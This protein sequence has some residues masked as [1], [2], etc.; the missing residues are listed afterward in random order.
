MNDELVAGL[1]SLIQ[2]GVLHQ[3]NDAGGLQLADV[4]I[5][6]GVLRSA[7]QVLQSPGMACNPGTDGVMAL[8]LA[9]GGDSGIPVVIITATAAGLGKL[10][11]GEA[12][13]YALDNLARVHCKPG[14]EVHVLAAGKV[15][16][17]APEV[18]VTATTRATVTAPEI[19]L[20]GPTNITGDVAITGTLRVNG[21]VVAVP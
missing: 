13:L 15:V 19:N 16:V 6:E 14:G 2:R 18:A 4:E 3:V 11:V 1:R 8:V 12:V 21:T 5:A 10:A 20:V 9:P 17:R 7:A